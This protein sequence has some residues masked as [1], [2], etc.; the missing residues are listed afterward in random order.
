MEKQTINVDEL[1]TL[2]GISR[3]KAYELVKTPGFPLIHLG[4]RLLIPVEAF[5]EWLVIESNKEG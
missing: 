3:P 5:K 1:A 4:T 2:M